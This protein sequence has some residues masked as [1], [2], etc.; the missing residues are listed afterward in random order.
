MGIITRVLIEASFGVLIYDQ[1]RKAR[2]PMLYGKEGS[3]QALAQ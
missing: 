2:S 3:A 1:S